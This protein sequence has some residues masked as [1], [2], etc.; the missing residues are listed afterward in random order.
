[1]LNQLKASI[2]SA[3]EF[4]LFLKKR[5][6]IEESHAT[7]LK[8]LARLSHDVMSQ[9]DHRQG[10]FAQSYAEMM[11]IHER[12]AENGMQFAASLHAM[13][14]DLMELA[15]VAE[16]SRKGW[17]ANGLAPEQRV[18]DLEA[19]LRKAKTKYDSL[20]EEYDR[21]RTGDTSRQ[22][23]KMFSL[24]SKSGPA[25]EEDLLRKVQ[26]ADQDYHGK[27]QHLQAERSELITRTRPEAIKALQELVK[28]TDSG[29]TLQ[30]QKFGIGPRSPFP[31]PL[32]MVLSDLLIIYTASFSEKLLL[33]NGLTI[34]P[35]RG[36]SG[37]PPATRSL[38][39]AA[40]AVNNERDL[41]DFVAS[42]HTRLPPKQ[43]ELKYER[44]PV[45]SQPQPA[46][47]GQQQPYSQ[48][49]P[50]MAQHSQMS[51]RGGPPRGQ[52]PVQPGGQGQG[53]PQQM[54]PPN[55]S[56]TFQNPMG[57]P[58]GGPPGGPYGGPH[59]GPHGG[60]PQG[61]P[62]QGQGFQ[63]PGPMPPPGPHPAHQNYPPSSPH[64]R[65]VSYGNSMPP[66]GDPSLRRQQ[67]PPSRNSALPSAT[68]SN[69]ASSQGPPQLGALPFQQ[70]PSPQSTQGPPPPLAQPQP[71]PQP[72]PPHPQQA[73]G[74]PSQGQ[75]Q[76]WQ[77]GANPLQQ[78][79]PAGSPRPAQAPVV[80]A[81]AGSQASPQ[82]Q[83]SRPSPPPS[84]SPVPS[85]PVFGMPLN[86]LYERDGLAVPM[87]VYQ[88]IQAVDLF[89]LGLE[90]IYRQSGSMN[91]INKLKNMFDTDSSNPALD[92]R[93][94][95][96]F[97]HDVNSVTGLLKQFF[98]DLPDPLLTLEQH[99]A[100]IEAAKHEDDIVRRDSLHAI[101]NGL[102]DP[103]YA[104]MRALTLHL[105]R[106]MDNSHINRMNSH[107]L[108]V[109][110]G[111]TLMGS[112]PSTSI[113][114]AGWQ[115]KAIDTILQNTFQIFDDD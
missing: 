91:H 44:H 113:A 27:V 83:Q 18:A 68:Y 100:L 73:Q 66:A 15:A 30:L 24:K 3:K 110:L 21:V 20:A 40:L 19:V 97:Y 31:V 95:E 98:R 52:F 55:R 78:H 1:M 58:Q 25:L 114:D 80:P 50:Q 90:G 89:G 70:A 43:G 48:Q 45:L 38:R 42:H 72:Q 54:P 46:P 7:S 65:S 28:E 94:P 82:A 74:P 67:G 112:D 33:S 79:P 23:G 26:G 107:N 39:D 111:P 8:K 69:S 5:S 86:K 60:F 71:Q 16:R 104:T 105:H 2:A 101:I 77:G 96:N 51:P 59:G 17:K 109:I 103:N 106:V 64:S 10:T 108:A 81:G 87:V 62:P 57:G 88:C 13:H 12:M 32:R 4:A 14:D 53:P 115:I 76:A 47:L 85:R 36:K 49:P 99:A 6:S 63:P 34:S 84:G 41:N 9:P 102:P 35:I 22:G 11:Y 56:S 93:N 75:Y 37:E 61:G 92:F 29:V